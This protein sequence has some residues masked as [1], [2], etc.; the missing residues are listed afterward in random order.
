MKTI[1]VTRWVP[2]SEIE[3]IEWCGDIQWCWVRCYGRW[4]IVNHA[5]IARLIEW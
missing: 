4:F 1:K 3:E 5:D 2:P